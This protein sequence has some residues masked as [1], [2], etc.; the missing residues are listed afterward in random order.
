MEMYLITAKE[1]EQ[2][3]QAAGDEVRGAFGKGN[4]EKAA[5]RL[6]MLERR[7]ESRQ[8]PDYAMGWYV[9]D[10]DG[11]PKCEAFAK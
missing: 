1:L 8:V 3:I 9:I 2:I 10:Y 4:S 5:E 6:E 11:N 7:V